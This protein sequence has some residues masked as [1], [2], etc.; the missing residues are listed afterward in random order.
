MSSVQQEIA[1]LKSSE[2][3]P[4]DVYKAAYNKLFESPEWE[5]AQ[6]EIMILVGREL[7]SRVFEKY[8]GLN[9][10]LLSDRLDILTPSERKA[11][12]HRVAE[13]PLTLT[14]IAEEDV[15]VSESAIYPPRI[16]SRQMK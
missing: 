3:L 2:V 6:E 8:P 16:N 4:E 11:Q 15:Q 10:S 13:P 1:S 7:R 12:I 14:P 9:L 5:E